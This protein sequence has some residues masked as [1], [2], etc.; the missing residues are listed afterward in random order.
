[1]AVARNRIKSLP[2]NSR[3]LILTLLPPFFQGKNVGMHRYEYE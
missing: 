1:M 2:R 3:C